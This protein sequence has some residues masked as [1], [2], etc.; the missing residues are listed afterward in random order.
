VHAD[1]EHLWVSQ[2]MAGDQGAFAELVD[3]YQGPVY[4]LCYRMLGNPNEA[5][6]AAQETFLRVYRRFDSYDPSRKFS[7]WILSIASHYCVDRL[8]RRRGVTL[9]MEELRTW[10]W[11]PD[12]KPK[13]EDRTLSNERDRLV[14]DLLKELPE[15]Y[16][17]A[18]ILRYW[19]DLS[20]EEIADITSSTV[21]AVKSRLHRARQAMAHMLAEEESHQPADGSAERRVPEN[22]LSRSI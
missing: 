18:I 2:A 20:Y 15:Q 1:R 10:R 4:N 16:R 12:D 9:S 14:R 17:L 6:D 22:A 5:E 7:S 21:S 19:H 11:L 13:P 8:R 3:A